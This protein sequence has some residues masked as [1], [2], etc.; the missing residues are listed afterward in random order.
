M[1]PLPKVWDQIHQL[2]GFAKFVEGWV[3]NAGDEASVP[4]G[5]G[6]ARLDAQCG[7]RTS[8]DVGREAP[9]TLQKPMF[10]AQGQERHRAY[11]RGIATLGGRRRARASEAAAAAAHGLPKPCKTCHFSEEA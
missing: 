2:Q 5:G 8:V 1:L 11:E 3:T 10:R 4:R 7:R 6:P 9:R